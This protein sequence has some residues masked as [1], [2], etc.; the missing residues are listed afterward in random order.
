MR[1]GF[2]QGLLSLRSIDL[3]QLIDPFIE[4]SLNLQHRGLLHLLEQS[5]GNAATSNLNT[6]GFQPDAPG[7][8]APKPIENL[9]QFV[10]VVLS[11]RLLR[12]S[13]SP[14]AAASVM[15]QS[16]E[17]DHGDTPLLQCQQ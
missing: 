7:L 17:I 14:E 16:L 2:A 9:G 4:R 10:F 1:C 3:H 12:Q 13:Q 6:L 11:G 5:C 8:R 15:G